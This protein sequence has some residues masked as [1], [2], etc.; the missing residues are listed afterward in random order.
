MSI[1]RLLMTK[2]EQL[3]D[4]TIRIAACQACGLCKDRL[5]TVPGQGNPNAEL[6]FL[7][8][9]PGKEEDLSGL[10]MVGRCGQL[11]TK[12]IIAMGLTREEVFICNVNKCRPPNNRPPTPEEMKACL[13]FLTEQLNIIRP[14]VI[15]A[16]GK[17]AGVGLGLLKPTDS[18]GTKRG[19][20][21]RWNDIP[22]VLTYHPSY[23]LRDPNQKKEVW[24][25]LQIL[26]PY[27]TRKEKNIEKQPD[28]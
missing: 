6:V 20:I 1:V 13:P 15:C 26:L 16:L 12:M 4:I 9:A 8:E 21:H 19:I 10:A 27:I 14:K 7:A 2:E 3:K 22:V 5:L 11:L 28:N 24:K 17:T 23:L 25:D 18:L